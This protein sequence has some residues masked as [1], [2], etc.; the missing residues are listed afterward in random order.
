MK[1]PKLLAV[2]ILSVSL[3]SCGCEDL[4]LGKL[5]F[6]NKL[7]AFVPTQPSE[8]KS[9]Y[10]V[11]NNSKHKM[12][13]V[14]PG[15]VTQT[16]IPVRKKNY[17]GKYDLNYCEEYY[18]AEV[19]EYTS[20]TEG[21]NQYSFKLIYRKDADDDINTKDK[22]EDMLEIVMGYNNAFTKPIV[23]NN[24][25]YNSYT[26]LRHFY[27]RESVVS[28]IINACYGQEFLQSITLN[29]V[30][31]KSVYHIYLKEMECKSYPEEKFLNERFPLDYIQGIYLKEGI[32]I[33][34]AYT[35]KGKQVSITV[36]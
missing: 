34:Y 4:H 11:F 18:T 19:R 1:L 25:T 6:T 13:Y 36:E 33:L 9:F 30:E 17:S 23:Y 31:H 21:S 24:I 3:Y 29:G 22:L 27:L 26:T 8:G 20:Q 2:V 16:T 28:E 32:G 10:V 5:E 35:S 14:I 7:V 15:S 12:S